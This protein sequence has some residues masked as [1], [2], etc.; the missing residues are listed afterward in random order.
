MCTTNQLYHGMNRRFDKRTVQ[1]RRMGFKYT[2]LE[3]ARK[4]NEAYFVKSS[5][6]R[7]RVIPATM[8]LLAPNHLYRDYL[9]GIL[10]R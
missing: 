6:W 1:L 8:V 7:D 2:S 3:I 10:N 9:R 4:C 5:G